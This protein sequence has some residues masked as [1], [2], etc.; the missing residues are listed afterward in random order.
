M[1]TVSETY[2]R[3]MSGSH[4]FESCLY[5]GAKNSTPSPV[6]AYGEEMIY[7]MKTKRGVFASGKPEVGCCVAGEIDIEMILPETAI[8]RMAMLVPYYRVTN[9]EEY[10]EWIQKGVFFIDTR[11]QTKNSTP[12]SKLKIH[13]YDNMLKTGQPYRT[14]GMTWPSNARAVVQDILTKTGLQAREGMLARISTT[15]SIPNPKDYTYREA[16]GFIAS[17]H[18]GN[19][20]MDDFGKL[21]LLYLNEV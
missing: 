6:N 21:R 1:Q 8:P 18:G 12:Q 15:Y 16:L 3:L 9:G 11:E 7:S 20:V 4:W 5:I 10:S 13:G 17:M 19:F 14:S 2:T